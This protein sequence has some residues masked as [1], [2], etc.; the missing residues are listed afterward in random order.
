MKQAD[1]R[2]GA[3]TRNGRKQV[4]V[5]DDSLLIRRLARLGLEQMAGWDIADAES[6]GDALAHAAAERP[7]AILLDV[8][9]PGMD[10]PETLLALQAGD[11]TKDIPVIFVTAKDQPSD[12]A[13]FLSL[14]AA[15]VIAKPFQVDTLAG[16]V[17]AI[18]DR[19]V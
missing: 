3:T 17:T 4:L 13:H 6:G 15:G 2:E 18:L 19:H 1:E 7:E 12:R 11:L 5:V 9:M 10:G 8:V 14:G 16:Q